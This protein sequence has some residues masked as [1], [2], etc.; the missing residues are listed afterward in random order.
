[1]GV[2]DITHAMYV[3]M[4]FV[5]VCV[6]YCVFVCVLLKISNYYYYYIKLDNIL[7]YMCSMIVENVSL[8]PLYLIWK[9]DLLS[10]ANIFLLKE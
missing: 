2:I 1:M 4:F 10:D 3:Y 6:C 8:L 9:A 5:Y 7:K